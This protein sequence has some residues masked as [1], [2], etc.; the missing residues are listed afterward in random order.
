MLVLFENDPKINV[1]VVAGVNDALRGDFIDNSIIML[2]TAS[3]QFHS[4]I[5]FAIKGL[6]LLF[7]VI[8]WS[9]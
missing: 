6:V 3:I 9:N 7:H 4:L 2:N 1:F 8:L 5:T